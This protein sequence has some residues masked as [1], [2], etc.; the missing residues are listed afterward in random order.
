LIL[1]YYLP[2]LILS[3]SWG[4]LAPV[5]PLYAKGLGANYGMVGLVLAGEGL[6]LLLG[7]VPGGV[8]MRRLGHKRTMLLGLVCV[9]LATSSLS[10]APTVWVALSLRIVSG[11]GHALFGVTQHAYI[12]SVASTGG[13]GRAIALHGGVMRIGSFIGP[14][15]GGAFAAVAG[16]RPTFLLFGGTSLVALTALM[17]FVRLPMSSA[18]RDAEGAAPVSLRAMIRSRYRILAA[19]GLGQ[20]LAQTIR[21]GRSAILPLYAA[22]VVGLDVSQI[23]LVVSLASAIDMS[24]FYPAGWIMDNLGRKCAIVPSFLLQALGMFLLPFAH[25]FGTLLAAAGLIAFG[26]GIGSGSMM[27]LGADL[28]PKEARGEF[29]GVWRLI[30]DVG[31]SGGPILVGQVAN[32]VTLPMAAWSVA[33]AGL[34]AAM[35]FGL[36]VPEPVKRERR[37]RPSTAPG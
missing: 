2:S 5:L 3:I 31:H 11:F 13:R 15:V 4:I 19:A 35:V 30:G 8:L 12:A 14:M 26:N 22:D 27:T 36:L 20:L 28:A 23:G 7:D 17:I 16:L 29:L 9:I 21:N 34:A 6:G 32:L 1:P 37:A 33:A 25:S 10:W 18:Q 24:L